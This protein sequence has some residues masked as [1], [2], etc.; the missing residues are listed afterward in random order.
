MRFAAAAAPTVAAHLLFLLLLLSTCRLDPVGGIRLRRVGRL[1]PL[2]YVN[3]SAADDEIVEVFNA[4]GEFIPSVDAPFS[5][6]LP[7]LLH[8]V[9]RPLLSVAAA[10]LRLGVESQR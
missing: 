5:H 4:F 1:C 9:L 2:L 7:F 6:R 8:V 3:R 10:C